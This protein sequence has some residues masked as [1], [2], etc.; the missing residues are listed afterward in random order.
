MPPTS[1]AAR[2]AALEAA[3]L[4]RERYTDALL[5]VR[6]PDGAEVSRAGG[7]WD[8]LARRYVDGAAPRYV[9]LQPSQVDIAVEF[10]QWRQAALAGGVN[11]IRA[12]VA[13]GGRGSGKTYLLGGIVPV[14]VAL[15]WPRDYQFAISVQGKAKRECQEAIGEVA[16]PRWIASESTNPADPF[17]EFFNGARILWHVGTRPKSFRFAGLPI[18]HVLINEGQAQT[19]A[20]FVNAIAATRNKGA[21]LTIATNAPQDTAG[22][23]IARLTT[24]IKGEEVNA[25]AFDLDPRQNLAVDQAAIEDIGELI[26][27]VDEQAYRADVLGKMQ[28]S[29]TVGYPGFSPVAWDKGGHL[30]DL[31]D[32]PVEAF[33]VG[34]PLWA[35]V[36]REVT[37]EW[38]D[39]IGGYDY[40]AGC[41]FQADPGC[42]AA[43]GKIYERLDVPLAKGAPRESRFVLWIREFVGVDGV[44]EALSQELKDRGYW[45]GPVDQ[46]GRPAASCLLIG[47]ATG[48]NRQNAEHKKGEPYSFARF[49]ADG[50]NII[51][52]ATHYKTKRPWWAPVQPSRMQMKA[53]FQQRQIMLAPRCKQAVQPFPALVD[54]FVNTKTYESGAFVKGRGH[55]THGPDCVRYMAWRFMPRPTPPREGVP[56]FTDAEFDRLASNRL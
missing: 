9:D 35:D 18:R 16:D 39:A 38:G 50:W 54:G 51:G 52:P 14:I 40:I 25:K 36:T 30:G 11:R 1:R 2:L 55:W 46:A 19:V 20:S 10:E 12:L 28:L 15:A 13:M 33:Q 5:V 43:V 42:C 53:L 48:Y 7:R 44:E 8:R 17:T 47:D 37:L 24:K 23:W 4:S 27:A 34:R 45:P 32:S 6:A 29:G 41:D 56:I 31:F 49:K 26:R 21:L 22:D 3:L